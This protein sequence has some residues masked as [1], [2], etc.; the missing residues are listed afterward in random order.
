MKLYT[1]TGDDGS[2]SLFGG[3]RVPKAALRVETYGGID[4]TNACLG[5]VL[6]ACP[7]DKHT[8][9]TSELKRIQAELFD[10]GAHLATPPNT[11]EATQS[12]L[13]AFTQ[14]HIDRLEAA[15][16]HASA[17]VPELRTFILPG[18]SEVATRLHHARTICRRVERLLVQ[19]AQAE[20]IHPL[21]II[22]TNRLSDL[23]FALARLANLED[24]HPETIWQPSLNTDSD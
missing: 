16:D 14:P 2:T 15:I 5:L 10:L 22:Y 24:N 19:L 21:A 13:P 1:R 11:S 9:I 20:T 7:K 12:A 23:L 4:E 6:A 17:Q 8:F 18:G 3:E